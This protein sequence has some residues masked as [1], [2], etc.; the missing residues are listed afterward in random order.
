MDSFLRPLN[1]LPK[2]HFLRRLEELVS[3]QNSNEAKRQ[4]PKPKK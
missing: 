1:M 4:T 3:E 2:E